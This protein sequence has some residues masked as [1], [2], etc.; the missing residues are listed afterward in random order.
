ME[1]IVSPLAETKLILL[2][3]FRSEKV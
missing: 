2:F 3:Y 1:E